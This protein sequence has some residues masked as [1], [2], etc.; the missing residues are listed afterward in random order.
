MNRTHHYKYKNIKI[1]N[2]KGDFI[3]KFIE[4]FIETGKELHNIWQ[5]QAI[6]YKGWKVSGPDRIRIYGGFKNLENRGLVLEI[7]DDKYK[8]T[9]TGIRWFEKS[10]FKYFKLK[11]V[12]WDK[13][14]RIIIF[15]I[16]QEIHNKRNW[17][18]KKLKTLGFYMI[19]KSVFLFP[20]PCEEEL[21]DICSHLG[22]ADY[23]D[24]LV[25][26][27]IGFKEQEIKK[28]FQLK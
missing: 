19:Q 5:W 10:K 25:A 21:K 24:I 9:K 1:I 11:T 13:K 12:K 18:R 2:M 14:W 20:Y 26:D 17:L 28:F 16:P 23:I 8:F 3:P 15:D 6:Y 22:V 7:G 4:S 27:S